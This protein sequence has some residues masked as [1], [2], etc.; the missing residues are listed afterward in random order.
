MKNPEERLGQ[1][2]ERIRQEHFQTVQKTLERIKTAPCVT[3]DDQMAVMELI[4]SLKPDF[5]PTQIAMLQMQAVIKHYNAN[6]KPEDNEMTVADALLLVLQQK[7]AGSHADSSPESMQKGGD[8]EGKAFRS[9]Q[10]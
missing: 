1:M 2:R 6:R 7:T 9:R 4:D 3:R 8:C 5:D 10:S